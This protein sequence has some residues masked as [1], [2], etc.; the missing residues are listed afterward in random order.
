MLEARTNRKK[1]VHRD[2]AVLN[3]LD[4]AKAPWELEAWNQGVDTCQAMRASFDGGPAP[5]SSGFAII[6]LFLY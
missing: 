3:T 5:S 6:S 1:D 2:R 4:V